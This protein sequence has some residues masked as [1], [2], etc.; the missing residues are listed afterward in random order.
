MYL[1]QFYLKVGKA[2]LFKDRKPW[3]RAVLVLGAAAITV[4]YSFMQMMSGN[5]HALMELKSPFCMT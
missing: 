4:R 1:I 5:F 3:L 2:N